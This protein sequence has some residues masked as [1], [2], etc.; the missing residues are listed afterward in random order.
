MK[1]EKNL[2]IENLFSVQDK[3]IL[4]TGCG[5]IGAYLAETY[6]ANGAIVIGTNRTKEKGDKFLKEM[7]ILGY[8]KL[9]MAALDQ[10][11]KQEIEAL[12]DQILAKYGRIDVLLN[13]VGYSYDCKPEKY[14]EEEIRKNINI[15]FVSA[16]LVNQVVAAKAMIP[17]K[18]GKIINIGSIAGIMCHS[19]NVFAYEASKAAL[20]QMTKSLALC[21]AKY[22]VYVNAIAPTWVKTP[23][24]GHYKGD[25][26]ERI[27]R[28]HYFDRMS[29][30]QDYAG[31]ALFLA[32]DASSY[33]SGLILTVDGAWTCGRTVGHEEG[34][35]VQF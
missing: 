17:A 22:N 33:V 31:P 16:A 14:P 9:E 29:E 12:V 32:S 28:M 15:N 5:G 2:K 27:R 10:E 13:A 30:L 7:Q 8:S 23:M 34:Y 24:I 4:V 20:H 21:W 19:E 3:V 1:M 6:L 11:N 25:Y 26:Y 18:K 35:E